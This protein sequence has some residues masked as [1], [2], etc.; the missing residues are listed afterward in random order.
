MPE[1]SARPRDRYRALVHQLNQRYRQEW[2]RAEYLAGELA[3]TG[4]KVQV[5]C[6]GVVRSEFHSRQA[7]D[8]SQV[9]R[10]EPDQIVTASLADL[11]RGVVVS[12]PAMPD[13]SAKARFDDAA[14]ALLGVARSSELPARYRAD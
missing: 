10:M 8:M 5:V 9:P 11:A 14:S 7:I 2:E 13:D 12:I 3:G 6:P 1:P 4:V